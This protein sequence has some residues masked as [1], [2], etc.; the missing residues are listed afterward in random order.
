MNEG[1]ELREF[2][3]KGF[4]GAIGNK[5]DYKIRLGA[6]EWFKLG[7]LLEEDLA[8]INAALESHETPNAE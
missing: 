6:S 2:L 3:K 7:I 8:E 1:F 4:L 5:P